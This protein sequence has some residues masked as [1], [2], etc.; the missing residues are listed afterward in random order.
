LEQII[1]EGRVL[2]SEMWCNIVG[3]RYYS[4]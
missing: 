4:S 2:S 1:T 3:R